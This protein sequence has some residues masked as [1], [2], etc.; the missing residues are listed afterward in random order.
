ML[1][2]IKNLLNGV[3][4]NWALITMII[5]LGITVYVKAKAYFKLTNEQKIDLALSN[6]SVIMLGLVKKAE[7][8]YGSKTGIIKR[9]EVIT[10]VYAKFPILAQVIDQESLL[11]KIDIIIKDALDKMEVVLASKAASEFTVSNT[12][13]ITGGTLIIDS[14]ITTTVE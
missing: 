4:A 1:E 8:L 2:G 10:Q 7:D 13:N 5:G 12:S 11:I 6:A 3:I 9:S 14:T